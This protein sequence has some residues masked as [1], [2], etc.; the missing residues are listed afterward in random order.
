[1]RE[2][3]NGFHKTLGE[4]RQKPGLQSGKQ[5]QPAGRAVRLSSFGAAAV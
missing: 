5:E 2:L 3:G 4:A 1:M